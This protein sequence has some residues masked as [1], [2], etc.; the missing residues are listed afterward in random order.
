[1]ARLALLHDRVFP[2]RGALNRPS[3]PSRRCRRIASTEDSSSHFVDWNPDRE[4]ALVGTPLVETRLHAKAGSR[5]RSLH[6][7][8]FEG[9]T[10]RSSA[11]SAANTLA[12]LSP[13]D[14]HELLK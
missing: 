14:T 6:T 11:L 13:P 4:R 8:G 2:V 12:L 9:C 5:I 7:Q 1:M 3:R 10:V